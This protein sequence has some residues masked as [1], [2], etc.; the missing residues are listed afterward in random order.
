MKPH[1]YKLTRLALLTTAV[2]M[3][4]AHAG[5]KIWDGGALTDD[6]WSSDLNWSPN[7]SPVAGDSI[8]FPSILLLGDEA[9]TNNLATGTSFSSLTLTSGYSIAGNRFQ[10]VNGITANASGNSTSPS[11]IAAGVTLAA[12]QTIHA[13]GNIVL[14][15]SSASTLE[16][17]TF[18]QILDAEDEGSIINVTGP[19]TGS[20]QL[21]VR[22]RGL[23]AFNGNKTFS[24][25]VQVATGGRM[26]VNSPLALGSTTN[27]LSLNGRLIFGGSSGFALSEEV[28][29]SGGTVETEDKASVDVFDLSRTVNVTSVGGTLDVKGGRRMRVTGPL[30]GTGPLEKKGSSVLEITGSFTNSYSGAFSLSLG[31]VELN[32]PGTAIALAGPVTVAGAGPTSLGELLFIRPNQLPNTA[33]VTV[34]EFGVLNL[35]GQTQQLSNV[36]IL[37]SGLVNT[38]AGKLTISSGITVLDGGQGSSEFQG[39]LAMSQANVFCD[40]AT[41]ESCLFSAGL[42][43]AT[44]AASLVKKGG[45]SLT[46]NGVS[47]LKLMNVEDGTLRVET[48][49]LDTA[50]ELNGGNAVLSGIG[51]VASIQALAGTVAPSPQ[52]PLSSKGRVTFRASSS[53]K[54]EFDVVN[55]LQRHSQLVSGGGVTIENSA[56]V[57]TGISTGFN[58]GFLGAPGDS[59]MILQSPGGLPVVG[60]FS[61]LPEGAVLENNGRRFSI[62]YLGGDGNDIVLTTLSTDPTPAPTTATLSTLSFSKGTGTGGQDQVTITGS[63]QPNASFVLETSID[64]NLWFTLQTITATPSGLI[65]F[66]LNQAPNQPQRFFRLKL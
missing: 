9:T 66:T 60:N 44:E 54:I 27:G 35:N 25:P 41:G 42:S 10:T 12:A 55:S 56:L 39:A 50:V 45:G 13:T 24:G 4:T 6:D 16:G 52:A 49:S 34:N 11:T 43:G 21:T 37:A 3:F 64:L 30:T 7:G 36:N 48:A 62:S 8:F 63:A 28:N 65:N 40:V 51:T 46:L 19:L 5:T 18:N 61:G 20:G 22:G 57:L 59:F 32:K 17:G 26:R 47:T 58:T 38:G 53:L 1:F 23:V 29:L 33:V 31:R 14:T 15:F 2:S